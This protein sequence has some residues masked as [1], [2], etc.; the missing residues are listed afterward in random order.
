MVMRFA[1]WD[2]KV[3]TWNFALLIEKNKVDVDS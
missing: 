2:G 3:E 1:A